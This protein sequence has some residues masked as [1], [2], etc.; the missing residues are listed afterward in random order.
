A[1]VGDIARVLRA[2]SVVIA[3]TG[4]GLRATVRLSCRHP[5][6]TLGLGLALGVLAV[7]VTCARLSFETSELHLL[8]AGQP[9]L[10]RYREYSREFGELD[11]IIIAVRGQSV[12]ESK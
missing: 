11:E 6:V 5:R 1:G 10:E 4:R 7:L 12:D 3:L 2:A 9:Y 8:P